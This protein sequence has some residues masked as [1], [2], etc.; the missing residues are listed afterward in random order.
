M[1]N[2]AALEPLADCLSGGRISDLKWNR[3][4]VVILADIKNIARL[5]T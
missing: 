1:D 3:F 4:D 5:W 2:V